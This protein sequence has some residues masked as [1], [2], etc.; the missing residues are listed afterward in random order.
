MEKIEKEVKGVKIWR[1]EDLGQLH[2]NIT[3]AVAANEAATLQKVGMLERLL[4]MRRVEIEGVCERWREEMEREGEGCGVRNRSVM[5]FLREVVG[6]VKGMRAGE[7]EERVSNRDRLRA[8]L[9]EATV[10]I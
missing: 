9:Q 10:N 7:G 8:M 5:E 4:Q 3:G 6:E 1:K 2:S